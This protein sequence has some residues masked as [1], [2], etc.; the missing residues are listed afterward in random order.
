MARMLMVMNCDQDTFWRNKW[1]DY[2]S[3][4]GRSQEIR[5]TCPN[6]AHDRFILS[7]AGLI[8]IFARESFTVRLLVP[9]QFC[10][11]RDPEGIVAH[12]L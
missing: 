5:A 8:V 1:V 4:R 7:L 10:L 2:L 12:V 6:S 11:S 3:P 9:V